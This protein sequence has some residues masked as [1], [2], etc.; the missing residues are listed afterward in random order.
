MRQDLPEGRNFPQP[1]NLSQ[2]A[3]FPQ[4]HQM[5]KRPC[6]RWITSPPP[7]K[8]QQDAVRAGGGVDSKSRNL[9]GGGVFASL[10][11]GGVGRASLAVTCNIIVVGNFAGNHNNF[12]E[13]GSDKDIFV[14]GVVGNLHNFVESLTNKDVVVDVGGGFLDWEGEY[15]VIES[16]PSVTSA[17]PHL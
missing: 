7:L 12:V 2:D 14:G 8:F 1:S 4:C 16:Y 5:I 9:V 11:G 3:A 10:G 17:S 6:L 13:L 15:G